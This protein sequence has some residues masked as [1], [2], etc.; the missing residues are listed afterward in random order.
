MSGQGAI[1]GLLQFRDAECQPDSRDG[2][3]GGKNEG[4]EIRQHPMP[5]FVLVAHDALIGEAGGINVRMPRAAPHWSRREGARGEFDHARPVVGLGWH[6]NFHPVP[7]P[8]DRH[9]LVL[10]VTLA[11]GASPAQ[12]KTA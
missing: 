7:I 9:R 5:E 11:Q 6:S 2:Q 8:V 4:G 12:N 3:A 1:L 10:A